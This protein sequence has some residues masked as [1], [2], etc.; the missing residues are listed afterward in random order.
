MRL[1][2]PFSGS[3]RL[4][5]A[6]LTL[7]LAASFAC[8]KKPDASNDSTP[9]AQAVAAMDAGAVVD[10]E[11]MAFLSEA[12]SLHHQANI[13]EDEGD[14]PGAVTVMTRLVGAT[15]PHA[16]QKIPEVEEVLADAWAR[17]AE[18][19][20]KRHDLDE[21]AKAVRSG[22]GYA[23]DATYFRGHLL[24]VDGVIEEARAADLA[25][26]GKKDEAQRARARAIELLQEAVKVQEQVIGRALG[27][28]GKR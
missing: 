22:L 13:R 12:R 18:L 17:L 25:D 14:L 5:A 4:G 2:I 24:E 9:P 15:L 16:G 21:A 3:M 20:V 1:V 19:Q 23:P 6:L 27:D 28:A 11:V 8:A 26:A 10:L 7:A